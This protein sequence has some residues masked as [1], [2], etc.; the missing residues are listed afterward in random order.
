MIR[1]P[2]SSATAR[3]SLQRRRSASPGARAIQRSRQRRRVLLAGGWHRPCPA[4]LRRVLRKAAGEVRALAGNLSGVRPRGFTFRRAAA[5]WAREKLHMPEVLGRTL[6]EGFRG[7]LCFTE[8]HESHAASAF[9]PSPFDEAAIL[10]LDA[11]GEWATSSIGSAAATGSSLLTRCGSRTR[12]ACS[13]RP[14]PTTR[15]SR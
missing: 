10:T 3:S 6:G 4:R 13:T 14:S 2:P 15:A 8:H 7:D 1:R 12:W 11:V 9:F 5:S